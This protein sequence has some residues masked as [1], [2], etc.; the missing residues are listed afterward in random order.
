MKIINKIKSFKVNR[1]YNKSLLSFPFFL[2][3]SI[4]LYS[5]VVVKEKT[6]VHGNCIPDNKDSIAAIQPKVDI[7]VN[8][9]FDENGNLVQ[10]DSTYSEVYASPDANIQFFNFDN[11][12]LFSQLKQKM[13][14][15]NFFNDDFFNDFKS[16]GFNQDLFQMNPLINFN[17]MEEMI[18]KL[19]MFQLNDSLIIQPQQNNQLQQDKEPGKD[20]QPQKKNTIPNMITL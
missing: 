15:N 17:Q 12:S 6:I 5:F 3:I 16:L 9:K 7:K 4:V 13:N 20:N 19:K 8:K 11:D 18:N 10:Y 1:M 14:S 2:L